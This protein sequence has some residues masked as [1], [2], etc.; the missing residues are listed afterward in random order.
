M[1]LTEKQK[2]EQVAIDKMLENITK[3]NAGVYDKAI[4]YNNAVLITGYASFFAIWTIAKPIL[5]SWIAITSILLMIFSVTIFVLFEIYKMYQANH[6]LSE[7]QTAAQLLQQHRNLEAFNSAI[8]KI[9]TKQQAKS[10]VSIQIWE[11]ALILTVISAL[12]SIALITGDFVTVLIKE[13]NN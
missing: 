7:Y 11:W 5:N 9:E 6:N 10:L 13:L 1:L 2:Q 4:A 3:I 12:F 8:S